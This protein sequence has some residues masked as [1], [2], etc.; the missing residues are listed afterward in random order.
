MIIEID[1][2]TIFYII[3]FLIFIYILFGRNCGCDIQENFSKE[4]FNTDISCK[5]APFACKAGTYCPN[6]GMTGSLPCTVGNY[7][8]NDGTINPILCASGT[9]NS[10]TGATQCTTCQPGTYCP[11]Q[12]MTS[13]SQCPAGSFCSTAGLNT[14]P[15][16]EPGTFSGIGSTGCTPCAAG[17][18]CPNQG[19]TSALICPAGKYCPSNTSN[20]I[21]CP[22]GSYC[23]QGST[24][25]QPCPAGSYCSTTNLSAPGICPTGSYCPTTSTTTTCPVGFYCPNTCPATIT[26]VTITNYV[27][28]KTFTNYI[29]VNPLTNLETLWSR[30][31]RYNT[32]DKMKL[33]DF[34]SGKLKSIN[35]KITSNDTTSN[36]I[37]VS[38]KLNGSPVAFFTLNNLAIT[39]LQVQSL[40]FPTYWTATLAPNVNDTIILTPPNTGIDS[41]DNKSNINNNSLLNF[42]ND[43]PSATYAVKLNMTVTTTV[44][45][46]VNS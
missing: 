29:F 18:Y 4:N 33:I 21:D 10:S 36:S 32:S 25:P 5:T 3:L 37:S 6:T 15:L 28:T 12:G 34:G 31:A 40:S 1:F 7:C 35:I 46:N 17:T 27:S 13:A 8:P 22:V 14:A 45:L 26:P 30:P 42:D 39:N 41:I 43:V 2:K 44:D 16:C 19:S 20:P 9:Y 24:G 23:P 11:N 38:I